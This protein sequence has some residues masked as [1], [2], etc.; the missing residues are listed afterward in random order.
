ME[1]D[2]ARGRTDGLRPSVCRTEERFDLLLE[3]RACFTL[4]LR[5]QTRPESTI[6]SYDVPVHYEGLPEGVGF[7]WA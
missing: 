4:S 5:I 6:D 2:V 1:G 3:D 7:A